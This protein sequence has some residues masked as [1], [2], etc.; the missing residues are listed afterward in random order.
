[1]AVENISAAQLRELITTKGENL[2]L[3]D[4]RQE[5]EYDAIHVKNSKLIPMNELMERMDEI[6]W[7]K[8][9]VFI[10]RSGSRSGLM[11]NMVS[12]QGKNVKNLSRGI[13]ECYIS[14]HKEYLEI[15]EKM[16]GM[17]F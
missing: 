3:I 14:G 13:Y 15:N 11:A 1:M 16:I 5:D 8:D 7:S 2:E 4:V 12:A 6:D 10:C 9:V 17:Y